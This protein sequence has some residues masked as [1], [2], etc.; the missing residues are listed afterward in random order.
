MASWFAVVA[1]FF[2][3]FF[4]K[5][6]EA[7]LT[8]SPSDTRHCKTGGGN[9]SKKMVFVWRARQQRA[10]MRKACSYLNQK[11]QLGKRWDTGTP[12]WLETV[13]SMQ[14]VHTLCLSIA[15]CLM[16]ALVSKSRQL[17]ANWSLLS[18]CFT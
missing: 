8:C 17:N 7:D 13:K 9:C 18:T 11:Q 5:A 1:P 15:A 4:W 10:D 3:Y 16:V 14:T 2:F 12:S 6:K